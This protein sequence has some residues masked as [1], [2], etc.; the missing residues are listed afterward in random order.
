ML[1]PGV[2]VHVCIYVWL[3]IV[4]TVFMG[5][6]VHVQIHVPVRVCLKYVFV[7]WG[8]DTHVRYAHLFVCPHTHAYTLSLA[9]AKYQS[10]RMRVYVVF[11]LDFVSTKSACTRE[12]EMKKARYRRWVSKDVGGG[13]GEEGRVR[14]GRGRGRWIGE[15]VGEW[16]WVER[17][18][19]FSR[20]CVWNI[21]F[22]LNA[23]ASVH[24]TFVYIC[25]WI[26]VHKL[27]FLHLF[28]CTYIYI[29]KY[30]CICKWIYVIIYIYIDR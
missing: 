27:L 17:V 23:A 13:N 19:A 18:R 10:L 11:D 26:C 6:K 4:C 24:I 3:S 16:V 25:W 7:C 5:I 22:I 12:Q 2:Y 8:E 28:L 21:E 20:E 29:Y 1:G 9:C 15:E 30:I 14:R